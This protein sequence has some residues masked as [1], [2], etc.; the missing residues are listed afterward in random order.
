MDAVGQLNAAL[1]GRYRIEREIGRGGMAVVYLAE[2]LRHRRSV[3][4]KVLTEDLSRGIGADR[5]TREIETL[6][7]LSHPHVL[8]LHDSGEAGGVL[9]YVTPYVAGESLRDRLRRDRQLPLEEAI[10]IAREVAAGLEYAH[11]QGVVHRD[12]KPENI[13][14]HHATG[15]A[16]SAV[17]ADFG[18]ARA[19][20]SAGDTLT[21]AGSTIGTPAYMSPEQASADP[22]L[23]A[24]SDIYS[25]GCV[26]YEMLAGEP[27]FAGAT[28]QAIIVKRLS[29]PAPRVRTLRDSAPESLEQVILRAMARTPA[30]RFAS[31]ADFAR[32]LEGVSLA[33]RHA[34]AS[35]GRGRVRRR[36]TLGAA[37]AVTITIALIVASR[38]ARTRG[39]LDGNL[40][41]VAPFDVMDES[42]ALWREGFVD[43]LSR[44]FDGAGALRSVPPTLVIR[45]WTGRGR[46]DG[47][48]ADELARRTGAGLALLGSLESLGADS[49]RAR[50]LIRD[51]TASRTIAEVEHR[52]H[53][54]GMDRLSDSLTLKLLR[55]LGRKRTVGAVR[56]TAVRSTNLPALKAFLQGEQLFR[57]GAYD[58]ARTWYETAV[59]HD[60]THALAMRRLGVVWGWLRGGPFDPMTIAYR[61]RADSFNQGFGVRD[62]LIIHAE[63]LQSASFRT[64]GDTASSF[65]LR[66]VSIAANGVRRFPDDPEM[67][68]VLA[69]ARFHST[70]GTTRQTLAEFR[71]AIALDS[72]FALP[73]PHAVQLAVEIGDTALA[74]RYIRSLASLSPSQVTARVNALFLRLLEI[75]GRDSPELD[76]LLQRAAPRVLHDVAAAWEDV[77]DDAETGIAVARAYDGRVTRAVPGHARH[78][79]GAALAFR[80]RLRE[81]RAADV[82]DSLFLIE[83]AILGGLPPDSARIRFGQWVAA[84]PNAARYA[85]LWW[86]TQ[87]DT[88]SLTT[89]VRRERSQP[90]AATPLLAALRRNRTGLAEAFLALARGD[91]AGALIRIRALP[92]SLCTTDCNLK[93]LTEGMLR[94]A[95]G[96]PG[97]LERLEPLTG[98]VVSPLRVLFALERGRAAERLNQP[99]VAIESYGL[100]IDAWSRADA[101]LQPAV[102]EA[103]RA[104]ERLGADRSRPAAVPPRRP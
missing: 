71:R 53:T 32:A 82:R 89:F 13:L 43:V 55:D 68:D 103:R 95:R 37:A 96:D 23:D 87:R 83:L 58:S 14:L 70:G 39:P 101:E 50:A 40:I 42:L 72:L 12:I 9:Y 54:S 59:A 81:A 44:N 65:V 41:A 45:R 64:S 76:T 52:E 29:E 74:R 21:A 30:D 31:A 47:A 80:G 35:A 98:D 88:A 100:V 6:A 90:A 77:A 20:E 97:A 67:W 46:A 61:I 7:R 62:S 75:R 49:V 33:P 57:R 4:L 8:P 38:S 66:L 28:A 93:R 18:I 56:L 19:I 78:H 99:R 22:H 104:L 27:P 51:V 5:F 92:D 48:S 34:D 26:L 86:A 10:R 102:D 91:S 63:S 3:A 60:S 2:D 11:R 69:D 16:G 84:D 1:A 85:F 36:I 94:A 17:V 73:Y 24:R 25:L 15:A 79:A